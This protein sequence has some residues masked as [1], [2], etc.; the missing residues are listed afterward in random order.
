MKKLEEV[1]KRSGGPTHTFVEPGEYRSLL[2]SIRTPGRGTI[3]EG[4]SGIGKTTSTLRIIDSLPGVAK[5]LRLSGRNPHDHEIAAALPELGGTRNSFN[6]R[7][8]S[9]A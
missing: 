2:V 5:V 1:F 6:R 8:S 3:V 9:I 4:P 7:L